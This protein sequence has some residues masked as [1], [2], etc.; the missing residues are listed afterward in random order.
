MM[1]KIVCLALVW[2]LFALSLPV[3]AQ[4]EAVAKT[5]LDRTAE[6]FKKSDGVEASFTLTTYRHGTPQSEIKGT[7]RLRGEK[8]ALT[9]PDVI[10][11]FDGKTQWSLLTANNEVN[12]A[13][14]TREEL[15]TINPYA[16]LE[17]YRH[18]YN[19]RM[20]TVTSY[21]GKQVSEVCLTAEDFEQ[22]IANLTLYIDQT[23]LQ[24]LYIKLKEAGQSYNVIT[25]DTYRTGMKWTDKD[26]TFDAKQYPDVEVIDLR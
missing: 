22:Q 11:W 10:T 5:L 21:A 13:N 15:Q 1:K 16:F 23:T 6:A 3:S 2:S 14:P 12:V 24:P 8:F 17:M 19:Y 4:K 7:I 25:I 18:G 9:T 26:F 20:G